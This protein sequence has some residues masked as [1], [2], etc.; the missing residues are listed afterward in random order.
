MSTYRD[1]IYMVLDQLRIISD[2]S[3]WE[4]EHIIYLLN[5]H[6]AF[7]IKQRYSGRKKD[8]PLAT[9]QSFKVQLNDWSGNNTTT[10][11]TK[12]PTVLNLNGIELESSIT[13]PDN[14]I[15]DLNVNLVPIDRLKYVG[16]NTYLFHQIYVSI[17]YDNKLYLKCAESIDRLPTTLQCN[18]ILENPMDVIPFLPIEDSPM[19]TIDLE[20]P[21]EEAL[22]API[23]DM[24]IKELASSNYLPS[25]NKNN[26]SDD[27]SGLSARS[28]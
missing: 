10:S 12:L 11:T 25:D 3:L 21:V 18:M 23:V 8:V 17:G 16:Y 7:I 28:K 9:Y 26:A 6:R 2:D 1:A 5:K 24:V 19:N 4:P 13:I 27:M 14:N 15:Q 20:F 22:V